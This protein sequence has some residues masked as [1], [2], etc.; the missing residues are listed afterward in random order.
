MRQFSVRFSMIGI[1]SLLRCGTLGRV[2][3]QLIAPSYLGSTP[4]EMKKRTTT[5][6]R[7]EDISQ[8]EGTRALFDGRV[9]G[10]TLNF[11]VIVLDAHKC[12]KLGDAIERDLRFPQNICQS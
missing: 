12:D 7:D 1:P 9:V 6:E 10:M 5:E 11:H 3:A 2:P 4:R 8:F